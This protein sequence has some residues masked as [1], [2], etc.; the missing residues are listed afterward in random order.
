[1]KFWLV[2]KVDVFYEKL[3]YFI[4]ERIIDELLYLKILNIVNE[5]NIKMVMI[6]LCKLFIIMVE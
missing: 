4:V 6:K 3:D 1:M 2:N 5:E